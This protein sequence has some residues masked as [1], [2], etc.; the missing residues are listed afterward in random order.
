MDRRLPGLGVL[1]LV[2]VAAAVVPSLSGRR[3]A[4]TAVAETFRDPPAIGDCAASAPSGQDGSFGEPSSVDASAVT[5]G[6]CNGPIVGEVVAFQPS[7]HEPMSPAAVWEGPCFSAA[8]AFCRPGRDRAIR[9]GTGR[10]VDERAELGARHW[11]DHPAGGARRRGAPR[12]SVV[13]CLLGDD[14]ERSPLSRHP[15]PGFWLRPRS[16]R[17]WIV[18]ERNGSRRGS[19]PDPVRPGAFHPAAGGW[20]RQGS[21]ARV[22]G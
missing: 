17:V 5:W 10:A 14:L 7:D 2:V 8:A 1:I 18:L 6:P 3:V 12:R 15:R 13:A 9:R 20:F 19:R 22:R 11:R 21:L 16:R 4:G